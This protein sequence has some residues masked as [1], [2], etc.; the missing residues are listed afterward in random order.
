MSPFMEFAACVHEFLLRTPERF[1]LHPVL[2]LGSYSLVEDKGIGLSNSG[3]VSV[4]RP[5]HYVELYVRQC[6]ESG[7]AGVEVRVME[8]EDR[9]PFRSGSYDERFDYGLGGLVCECDYCRVRYYRPY[10]DSDVDSDEKFFV[11]LSCPGSLEDIRKIV[12][13]R[14]W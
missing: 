12:L 13:L 1:R 4:L 10:A 5:R 6:P 14:R 8:W 9:T 3:W 2:H 7:A 11:D